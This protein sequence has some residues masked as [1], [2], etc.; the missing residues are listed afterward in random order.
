LLESGPPFDPEE[1]RFHRHGAYLTQREVVFL[2]EAP[3]VEWIVNDILGD[4]AMAPA[5]APWQELLDGPP[6][7]AHERLYWSPETNKL[8]V[9]L[10]A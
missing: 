10:G 8:G 9:G 3:D 7:L 6:R 1:L 2:F 4:P 5:F